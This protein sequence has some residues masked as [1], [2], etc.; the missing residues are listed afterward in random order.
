M[1]ITNK[2]QTLSNIQNV[3]TDSQKIA[4]VGLCYLAMN[5]A[6]NRLKD[7]KNAFD[8]CEKWIQIFMEKL[9]I[10]LDLTP[11]GKIGN[12]VPIMSSLTF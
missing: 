4:Y 10:Y 12:F 7:R 2:S 3:F 11:E 1:I 6:K 9:Y 8:S 5:E